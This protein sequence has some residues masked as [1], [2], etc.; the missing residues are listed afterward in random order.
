MNQKR[1]VISKSDH[2]N[3]SLLLQSEFTQAIGNNPYISRLR[4]ELYNA[5]IVEPDFIPPDIVTM[6]SQVKLIDQDLNEDEIYTLVYPDEANIN[7]GKLSILTP[8]GTA[9]FGCRI[10]EEVSGYASQMLIKEIIYQPQ[11]SGIMSS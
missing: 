9:I 1:I 11:R 5:D 8:I 4:G 7:D 6:N 3:L 2:R 10:G